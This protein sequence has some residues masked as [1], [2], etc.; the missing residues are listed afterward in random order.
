MYKIKLSILLLISF[1]IFS[2]T[3]NQITNS[4]K[5]YSVAY[6][7][8]EFDGL[9]LKNYIISSLKNLDVYNQESKFAIHAKIDH[10]SNLFIT[11]TDNTSDREKISTTLFVTIKNKESNC[12]IY[13]DNKRVSQFYIYASSDKFLSNQKA[14]KKIKKDNTKATVK[15]FINELLSIGD[16]CLKKNTK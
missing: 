10:S 16:K 1:F 11:N 2:C 9:L 14:V 8:G 4:N 7:G 15:Q 12:Q 3:N 5:K 6:I 13:S